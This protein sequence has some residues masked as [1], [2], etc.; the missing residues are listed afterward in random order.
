MLPDLIDSY[1]EF[2]D[3]YE[4]LGDDESIFTDDFS[5]MYDYYQKIIEK[6]QADYADILA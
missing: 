1:N 6:L 3:A 4:D 5:E 2:L